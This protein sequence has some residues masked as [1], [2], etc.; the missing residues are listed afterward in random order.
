MKKAAP[1]IVWFRQDLRLNDNPALVAAAKTKGPILFVYILDESQQCWEMGKA[2]CW[3][4][5]A[6]LE[7]LAISITK[8]YHAQLILLK[9]NPQEL[10]EDLIKTSA[11]QAVYWN[12][13]YEPGVIARDTA[14]KQFLKQR[15]IEV[16]TFNSA[17]LHE[18]WEYQ[19]R[20]KQPF[21]IFTPFWKTLQTMPLRQPLAIPKNIRS[22]KKLTSLSL[23]QLSLLSNYP[24]YEK[25]QNYWQAG[26][27]SASHQLKLFLKSGI[28]GYQILRNRP[29]LY[30]TS[31]LSPHLHFGEISPVKI[32][33]TCQ[34]TL[35]KDPSLNQDISCFLSE[36]AWREFSYHLLYYQPTLPDKPYRAAFNKFT[37]EKNEQALKS[38]QQG[39]TGYPIVDAAMR[40]LW[41]TGWMH[42][43]SRM[44]VASFL[45]KH[46]LQ[47]WQLGEAWFWDTL[48]DADLANNAASWQWV[49]GSGTDAAPYFR[50]FNP[51]LQ[52]HKFDPQGEY[53]KKWVPELKLLPIN[54][55]HAPWK[56]P[57]A[58]LEKADITLGK[59][60]PKPII[61]HNFARKRALE[62]YRKTQG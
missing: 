17:L 51:E 40:E 22:F 32:W 29:D 2:S 16:F 7:Q 18:P 56:A 39:L 57:S 4:L 8:Y 33:S 15:N 5:H 60:Y 21:K 23:E 38:W 44:I 41:E 59:T 35:E 36:L 62:A 50:I 12:R 30:N 31:R 58:V 34:Q 48:V 45:T 20:S 3:W 53:I 10:L 49:A 54:Y 19:N 55:I 14:I 9:G 42:N 28:K 26:E 13:C 24:W 47:P 43:R 25:L 46:L 1:V 37:W 11:A 27:N 52:A 6:S 61:E